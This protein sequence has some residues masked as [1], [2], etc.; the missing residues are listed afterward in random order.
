M[1]IKDVWD[2][3]AR[4]FQRMERD[5]FTGR[6]LLEINLT[7]GVIHKRRIQTEESIEEQ[8]HRHHERK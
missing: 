2:H 5:K 8:G 7:N 6:I 3:F 4:H 1:T